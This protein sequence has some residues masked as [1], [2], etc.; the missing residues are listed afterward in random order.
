MGKRAKVESNSEVE[1]LI[2]S[3]LGFVD[4][5]AKKRVR[6]WSPVELDDLVQ[7]GCVGLVEAARRYDSERGYEE[8]TKFTTYAYPWIHKYMVEEYLRARYML[9]VPEK[10]LRKVV[11]GNR[12]RARLEQELAREPTYGE[13]LREMTDG[14]GNSE[15]EMEKAKRIIAIGE[16]VYSLDRRLSDDSNTTFAD[17]IPDPDRIE[18]TLDDL[19]PEKMAEVLETLTPKEK[20]VLEIRFGIGTGKAYTLE[21]VAREFKVSRETIRHVEAKVLRKLRHPSRSRLLKDLIE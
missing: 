9:H 1:G 13:L 15:R 12:I 5:L 4:A 19:L 7:A 3:N 8:G 21:E 11:I 14:E 20:R 2:I 17:V 16:R 18:N 6:D 10:E